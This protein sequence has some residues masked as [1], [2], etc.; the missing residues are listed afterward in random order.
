VAVTG[1]SVPS[2]GWTPFAVSRL[3]GD[4][5]DVAPSLLGAVLVRGARAGRI[6]EVEAYRGSED[7]ASHAFRGQTARNA[8]L[9]R[10]LAP[11][12]GLDEMWRAR[13]PARTE[14]DLC[15][16]PAKLCQALGITG[17]DNGTS[18]LG[19][20]PVLLADDGAALPGRVGVSTRV[21]LRAGADLPLRFYVPGDPHMSPHPRLP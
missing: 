21:G 9:V 11:L 17:A 18:L 5:A 4:P 12:A 2:A 1:H 3:E 10:A 16:G 14:R 7:P 8:V 20:G 15:S 6:V 13:P 19:G